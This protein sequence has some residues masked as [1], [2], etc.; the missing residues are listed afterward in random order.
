MTSEDIQNITASVILALRH[1]FAPG[2]ELY[3][4]IVEAVNST[5][6]LNAGNIERDDIAAIK[7]TGTP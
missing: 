2:G 5:I 7:A 1:Q 6:A 3:G 4:R